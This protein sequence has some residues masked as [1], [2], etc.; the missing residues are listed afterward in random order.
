[1][2]TRRI[3]TILTIALLTVL[4]KQVI[5]QTSQKELPEYPTGFESIP[6]IQ[7]NQNANQAQIQ[8]QAQKEFERF[9]MEMQKNIPSMSNMTRVNPE[10]RV[11]QMQ[12]MAQEQEEQA[13]K[14]ALRV[15]E[16]QWNVIKPK[17]DKVKYYKEQSSVN[18]GMPFSSS[19]SSNTNSPGGQSF[20]GGFQ[21]SFGGGIGNSSMPNFNQ[22]N[23]HLTKGERICMDLQSLLNAPVQAQISQAA[24][25]AKIKELQKARL[26]AKK[27]LEKA[28]EE[29]KK[30]LNLQLQARLVLMGLLD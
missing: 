5:S 23:Q 27:Q 14:Q 29:L 12:K 1:M 26:E 25:Q 13:M 16:R 19:F 17:I 6:Q 24:I 3:L 2:L 4:S 10:E 21:F 11:R 9:Q 15:D 8:A 30:G 28:Q 20:A 18:I 7:I 22:T